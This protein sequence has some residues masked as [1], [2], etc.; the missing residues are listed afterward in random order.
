MESATIAHHLNDP[1]RALLLYQEAQEVLQKAA[2][3]YSKIILES[4]SDVYLAFAELCMSNHQYRGA[5]KLLM[6]IKHLEEGRE[7]YEGIPAIF[8][9]TR[10]AEVK[11]CSR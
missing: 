11:V 5:E 10:L 2:K 9:H 8:Y 3:P 1:R 7:Q 6:S 4:L